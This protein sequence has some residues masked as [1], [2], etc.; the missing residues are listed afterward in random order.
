MY[1]CLVASTLTAIPHVK[2]VGTGHPSLGLRTDGSVPIAKRKW[3]GNVCTNTR[4]GTARKTRVDRSGPSRRKNVQT[5]A[6]IFTRNPLPA[7]DDHIRREANAAVQ[8]ELADVCC[9]NWFRLGFV[10]QETD[11]KLREECQETR[12]IRIYLCTCRQH[13]SQMYL[14]TRRCMAMVFS[15]HFD[16]SGEVERVPT[17][18]CYIL[19]YKSGAISLSYGLATLGSLRGASFT[20]ILDHG[21]V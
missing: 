12:K 4:N 18:I 2:S 20:D 3:L 9:S 11:R 8:N 21:D 15:T 16:V 13:V 7:I 6:N 19:A 1:C 14:I 10:C 5:A 17:N